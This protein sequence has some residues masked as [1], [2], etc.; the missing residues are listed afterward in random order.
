MQWRAGAPRL[1]DEDELLDRRRSLTAVL[2]RPPDPEPPI[3]AHLAHRC[4]RGRATRLAGRALVE[5]LVGHQVVEVRAQLGA[6]R[7]LCGGVGDL[8]GGP[9]DPVVCSARD[10]AFRRR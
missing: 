2:G 9:L 8:H 6:Q 4:E 5:D 7:F 10:A 1:V 3:G